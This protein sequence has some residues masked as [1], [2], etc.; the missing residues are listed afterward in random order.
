MNKITTSSAAAQLEQMYDDLN[1]AFF[2]GE[3]LP[4]VIITLKCTKGAYGHFTTGQVWRVDESTHKHEI[5]I[6][7]ATLDRPILQTAATL[8]HE[9]VHFSAII[10]NIR[11]TS[12]HGV[13]HNHKYKEA[14]L[15][16]GLLVYY[17]K[18]YGWTNTRPSDAL[19]LLAVEKAWPQITLAEDVRL[20]PACPSSTRKYICPQCGMTCRATKKVNLICGDC[21]LPLLEV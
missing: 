3:L 1:N 12:N 19:R 7:S 6:S 16:H 11:D 13:Y 17:V 15:D 9:M 5:N 18:H 21:K 2:E 4:D 10:N 20:Y 8:L 14:A